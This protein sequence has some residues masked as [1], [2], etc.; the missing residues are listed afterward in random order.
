MVESNHDEER[1]A[2]IEQMIEALQREQ[3]TIRAATT[4]LVA[5]VATFAGNTLTVKPERSKSKRSW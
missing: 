5:V 3:V 4:K 1:L 2:R